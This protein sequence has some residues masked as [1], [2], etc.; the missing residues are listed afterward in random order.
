[1]GLIKKHYQKII[2]YGLIIIGSLFLIILLIIRPQVISSK[3]I[4]DYNNEPENTKISF[5][6]SQ[7]ITIGVPKIDHLELYFGDDSI[8]KHEYTISIQQD[9]KTIFEHT[10]INEQS[11]IIQIPLSESSPSSNDKITLNIVCEDNCN[12]VHMKLY[13]TEAGL[14]PKI[15]AVF[16]ITNL[17]YFWIAVFIL[18]VGLILFIVVKE[19]NEEK[20]S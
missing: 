14:S 13:D 3:P 16:R 18:T 7:E 6:F 2:S 17:K 8:N 1:M 9:S 11:N 4:Y 5:P 19:D 15:L 20:N 10:Y 12:N